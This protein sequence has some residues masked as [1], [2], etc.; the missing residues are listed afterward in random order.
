MSRFERDTAPKTIGAG[1]YTA[2]MD[3]AWWIVNGPNGGYLAAVLLRAMQAEVADPE[4]TPRSLTVHYLRPPR[5]G[6]VEIAVVL[7][8]SG[9]TVTNLT[10]RLSQSGKLQLLATAAFS[11]LRGGASFQDAQMPEVPAPEDLPAGGPPQIRLHE[12]YGRRWLWGRPPGEEGEEPDGQAALCGGWIRLADPRPYDAA[13]I[14]ALT[15]SWP[16]AIYQRRFARKPG[17]SP[18]LDLTIHF[19]AQQRIAALAPED[20]VLARFRSSM[21]RDGFLEEDGEIWSR[22]GVL[23]AHS[24]QLAVLR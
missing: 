11:T 24:R 4:R 3:T 13:L 9:R 1:R 19:R 23:L 16:P 5:Q 20:W 14:A 21:A 22:D 10:A 7:E 17:G 15:D 8:R 6:P 2:R 12:R 18:T